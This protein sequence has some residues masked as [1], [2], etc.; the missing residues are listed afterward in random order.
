MFIRAMLL[1]LQQRLA[2]NVR[3]QSLRRQGKIV[4]GHTCDCCNLNSHLRGVCKH[5]HSMMY[6]SIANN[7]CC[8]RKAIVGQS[9][10]EGLKVARFLFG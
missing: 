2:R 3:M 8:L 7:L 5:H 6:L 10:E 4:E 1:Q 9:R